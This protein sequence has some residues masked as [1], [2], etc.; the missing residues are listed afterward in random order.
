MNSLFYF[1]YISLINK[2][3]ISINAFLTDV[4]LAII[5]IL[6]F[7]KYST[8]IFCRCGLRINTEV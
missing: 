5:S 7:Q 8:V 1:Q 2:E 3:T 4:T 6:L